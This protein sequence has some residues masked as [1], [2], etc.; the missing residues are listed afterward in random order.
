MLPPAPP[1]AGL[2][3]TGAAHAARDIPDLG[4]TRSAQGAVGPGEAVAAAATD[5]VNATPP[6]ADPPRAGKADKPAIVEAHCAACPAP[7]TRSSARRMLKCLPCPSCQRPHCQTCATQEWGNHC[8][9]ALDPSKGCQGCQMSPSPEQQAAGEDGSSPCSGGS[10][11]ARG[12]QPARPSGGPGMF[13]GF[14]PLAFATPQGG[15]SAGEGNALAPIRACYA[16]MV[17]NPVGV[18]PPHRPADRLEKVRHCSLTYKEQH[19]CHAFAS[20]S[21]LTCLRTHLRVRDS[22]S[23][24]SGRP[25]RWR[26]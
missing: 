18:F 14:T 7:R 9:T 5:A 26:Q 1:G 24:F 10:S 6:G 12:S 13:A 19:H 21:Y 23:R 11:G 17:V 25:T 22:V 16:Q 4:A 15:D 8:F 2:N 3:C 20:V